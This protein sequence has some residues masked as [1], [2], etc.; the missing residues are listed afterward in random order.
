[1]DTFKG[2]S[3]WPRVALVVIFLAALGGV[4][5]G[6]YFW[7]SDPDQDASA[8]NQQ[9]VPVAMGNVVNQVSINGSLVFPRRES[10]R[11]GVSGV[12]EQLSVTEGQA[13]ATNQV[14]A[15]LGIESVASLRLAVDDA[16]VKLQEA[17]KSLADAKNPYTDLQLAQALETVAKSEVALRDAWKELNDLLVEPTLEEDI[18]KARTAQ[19]RAEQDL[20]NAEKVLRN[21]LSGAEKDAVAKATAKI[22]SMETALVNAQRDLALEEKQWA[23]KLQD[24]QTKVD[25]ALAD[26]RSIVGKWLGADVSQEEAAL[27]P[28][29]LLASWDADLDSLFAIQVNSRGYA[30]GLEDVVESADTPWSELV[31]AAWVN[32]FPHFYIPTCADDYR[33]LNDR[34][35]CISKEF[36]DNWKKYDDAKS[37]LETLQTQA[38]TALSKAGEATTQA[39]QAIAD[40]TKELNKL[41]EAAD[42]LDLEAAQRTITL[43][44]IVLK[45]AEDDLEKISR[46][47]KPNALDV[48]AAVQK[49]GV[50]QETLNQSEKDLQDIIDGVDLAKVA[51]RES[52]VASARIALDAA[53]KQ[54]HSSVITAPWN[55]IAFKVNAEVGQEVGLDTAIVEI[56]DPQLVEVD[57]SVDEIDVLSIGVGSPAAVTMD[58]RMGEFLRGT[59]S[60]IGSGATNQR[61][62]VTYPVNVRIDAPPGLD[63]REGM[64]AVA[65]VVIEQA[66]GLLAPVQ[67]LRG[68][69]TEPTVMVWVEEDG[70]EVERPVSLGISDGFWTI[71]T[72]GLSAGEQVVLQTPQQGFFQFGPGGEGAM[73]GPPP[74]GGVVYVEDPS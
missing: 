28:T 52:Q 31:V 36:G 57:G 15:T 29:E 33:S 58:A 70:E 47:P 59:V 41:L 42:P 8:E 17:E 10:L 7:V 20:A 11:F 3:M 64:T 63:L 38:F 65:R 22:D 39:S 12:V 26:Y 50:A 32:F 13:V 67:A 1:M 16:R 61:G 62:I 55:G 6:I 24:G 51:L 37:D 44:Q 56:V 34:Q 71:V 40:A 54:L 72:S 4:A 66:S 73:M 21:L 25:A 60:S 68:S 19:I 74:G 46:P 27:T 48:G 45:K 69:F 35:T 14:I 18:A 49:V 2:L 9:L 23:D 5:Y 43:A 30:I 53:T